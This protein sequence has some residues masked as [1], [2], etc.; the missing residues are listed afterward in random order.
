MHCSEAQSQHNNNAT[1]SVQLLQC[2][3]VAF[4]DC[5]AMQFVVHHHS[6]LLL[7]AIVAL[8]CKQMGGLDS[9]SEGTMANWTSTNPPLGHTLFK[10][11]E[12]NGR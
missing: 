1:I 4:N 11:I 3:A 2:S 6:A 5:G 7:S 12:R 10:G 8:H 9:P